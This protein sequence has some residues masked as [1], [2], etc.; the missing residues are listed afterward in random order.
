MQ[1]QAGFGGQYS[2]NFATNKNN[3]YYKKNTPSKATSAN[4]QRLINR[5]NND[6]LN[7]SNPIL[8]NSKGRQKSNSSLNNSNP[9]LNGFKQKSN[10]SLNKSNPVLNGQRQKSQSSIDRSTRSLQ[11]NP[12]SSINTIISSSNVTDNKRNVPSAKNSV[13]TCDKQ[14]NINYG[15]LLDFLDY[16]R[17][18]K[19][20]YYTIQNWFLTLNFLVTLVM[21]GFTL[22]INLDI[23]FQLITDLGKFINSSKCRVYYY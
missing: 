21:L 14:S 4:V 16:W 3:I 8:N 18:Q 5:S 20:Q 13:S 6:L 23:R 11:S 19:S 2:K 9:V 22:W 10:T 15:N 7:N 17:R 12:Y 1:N